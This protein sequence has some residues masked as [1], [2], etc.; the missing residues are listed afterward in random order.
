MRASGTGTGTWPVTL[1]KAWRQIRG[2]WHVDVLS[3]NTIDCRWCS[4]I[5]DC[6]RRGSLHVS[7]NRA[8]FHGTLGDPQKAYENY[9]SGEKRGSRGRCLC[10]EAQTTMSW[11]LNDQKPSSQKVVLRIILGARA[12]SQWRSVV[13]EMMNALHRAPFIWQCKPQVRCADGP[14][15]VGS[16]PS[17]PKAIGTNRFRCPLGLDL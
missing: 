6:C 16:V 5:L 2:P 13:L 14:T 8:S 3:K 1:G 11:Q 10:G 15:S 12:I 7:I 4:I 9:A 17:R